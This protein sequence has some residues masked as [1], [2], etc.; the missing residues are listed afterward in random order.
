MRKFPYLLFVLMPSYICYYITCM[1]VP[2]GKI[3]F[4]ITIKLEKITLE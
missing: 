4:R 1:A 2:L 3:S